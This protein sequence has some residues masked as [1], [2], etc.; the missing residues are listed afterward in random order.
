[1]IRWS[2]PWPP[3]CLA[4]GLVLASPAV[5]AQEPLF[6]RIRPSD[7][8]PR[9]IGSGGSDAEIAR[10][11][12]AAREAVWERSTMRANLAIA[13]VCTGCLGRT[14]APTPLRPDRPRP[15]TPPDRAQ[16]ALVPAAPSDDAAARPAV[17]DPASTRGDP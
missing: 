17:A 2:D 11:A 3:L 6:L 10:A 9:E 13:S 1:M 14:P 12:R 7:A 4:T 5:L 15:M 16:V 8:P